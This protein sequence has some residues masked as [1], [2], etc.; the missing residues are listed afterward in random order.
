[1]PP[2]PVPPEVDAFLRPNY[3]VIA[4]VRPDGSPQTAPI[5]YEWE[6]GRAL[7]NMDESR[8]RLRFIQRDPPVALTVLD[9]ESWSRHVSL[10]GQIVA[11][12]EDVEVSDIDRLALRYRGE[13]FPTRNRRRFSAWLDVNVRPG[14]EGRAPWP[15]R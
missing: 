3:A 14:W 6:S 12:E 7:A 11:I 13:P 2:A 8:L 5:W 1:V 10:L 9:H 4:S 15:H